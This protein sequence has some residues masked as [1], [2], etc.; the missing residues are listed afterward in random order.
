MAPL[1][2]TAGSCTLAMTAFVPAKHLSLKDPELSF[3][4]DGDRVTV[5]AKTPTPWVWLDAHDRLLLSDNFFAML[6]GTYEVAIESAVPRDQL[7]VLNLLD[8]ATSW[9]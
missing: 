2:S 3:A 4:L 9:A 8:T 7:T 5:T 6:P 1:T